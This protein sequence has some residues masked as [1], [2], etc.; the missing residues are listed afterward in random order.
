MQ[1]TSPGTGNRAYVPI[2][3]DLNKVKT[4]SSIIKSS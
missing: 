1:N 2:P 4:K 3:M